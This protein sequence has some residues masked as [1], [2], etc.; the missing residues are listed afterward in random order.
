MKT[1]RTSTANWAKLFINLDDDVINSSYHELI[2]FYNESHRQYHNLNHIN[3]CLEV[4]DQVKKLCEDPNAVEIAIWCHDI[5]YDPTRQDNEEK[6]AQW[7]FNILNTAKTPVQNASHIARLIKATC[8]HMAYD[9]DSQV[10]NDIDFSILGAPIDEYHSYSQAI[11]KEHSHVPDSI[12]IPARQ[13]LLHKILY[14][15]SIFNTAHFVNLYERS[16]RRNLENEIRSL[17]SSL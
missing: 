13:G 11:R 8:S 5:I 15:T 10:L 16:T 2:S 6:S 12:Y 3:N 17:E 14:R 1:S 9:T 4:F 7:I